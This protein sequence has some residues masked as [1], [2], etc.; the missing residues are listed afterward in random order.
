MM[1]NGS[2]E[3]D[4]EIFLEADEG[5]TDILRVAELG[6]GVGEGSLSQFEQACEFVLV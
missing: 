3:S 6:G 5:V 4:E 1:G 2:L